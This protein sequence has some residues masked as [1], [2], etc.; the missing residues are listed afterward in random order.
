MPIYLFV[1]SALSLFIYWYYTSIYHKVAIIIVFM[2]CPHSKHY[3]F[4]LLSYYD[5]KYFWLLSLCSIT[6]KYW[7]L[8]I[9]S[10]SSSS[11]WHTD[12]FHKCKWLG[13]G[14]H[15]G[16]GITTTQHIIYTSKNSKSIYHAAAHLHRVVRNIGAPTLS[17]Q[18][19]A[20]AMWSCQII[21]AF[22]R[23]CKSIEMCKKCFQ[24][25]YVYYQSCKK[26][27]CG[28]A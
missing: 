5:R 25:K 28:C 16:I 2:F 15:L 18:K 21:L 6:E 9:Q 13:G 12:F 1:Y 8:E 4:Y 3:P 23:N 19:A 7:A 24:K 26:A 14:G 27:W 22:V 10:Y 17:C 11:F 20:W